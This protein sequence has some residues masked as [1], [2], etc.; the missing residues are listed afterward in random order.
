MKS[1]SYTCP[2]C[3][4]KD[5]RYVGFKN[6]KPYCRLCISFQ[7][8][9][10]QGKFEIDENARVNIPYSLSDEQKEISNKVQSYYKNEKNTLICAVCGAGKTE[11]VY[12]VIEYALKSKKHVGFAIPRRDVVIELLPRLKSAFPSKKI[13]AVY[14]GHNA[15]LEGD[16]ILLTT[17]QLFRY[18]KYFDLLIMDEIDA[19]PFEGNQVLINIFR[20]SVKGNYV[21]MSA[22]PSK[23]IIEEFSKEGNEIIYL[24]TRFH[25]HPI[26]VPWVNEKI[27]FFKIFLVQKYLKNY[28]Q[29][30]K[31]CL[32]FEPTIQM[33]NDTFWALSKFFKKGRCTHSKSKNREDDVNNFKY[34]KLDYLVTTSIL[35]RGITVKNLQ[36]IVNHADHDLFSKSQLIQIAGRVGRKTGFETGDV[37]FICSKSNEKIKDCINEIKFANMHLEKYGKEIRTAEIL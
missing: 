30:N 29:Q 6:N 3:G 25:K 31:P 26:P 15:E 36:V 9:E 19:F 4:N 17:H 21:L 34:G 16:I 37:I 13:I 27:G 35:E 33:A 32:I 7:G 5:L 20:R 11:L 14:G 18:N 23:E 12:G 1:F 24:F 28:I 10:A 22:T 2:V 8:K